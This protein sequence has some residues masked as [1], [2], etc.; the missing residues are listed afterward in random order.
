MKKLIII[1]LL[2]AFVSGCAIFV[3]HRVRVV[4][5]EYG[6]V[7]V[8]PS[9]TVYRSSPRYTNRHYQ[10]NRVVIRNHHHRTKVINKHHYYKKKVVNKHIKHSHSYK[11]RHR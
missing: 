2:T 1:S 3:P 7:V 6:P 4:E 9:P 11:K 10:H 8:Y 5:Y